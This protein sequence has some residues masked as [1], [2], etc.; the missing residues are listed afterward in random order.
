M[1]S[2]RLFDEIGL[3]LLEIYRVSQKYEYEPK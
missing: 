3:V 2:K 1:A